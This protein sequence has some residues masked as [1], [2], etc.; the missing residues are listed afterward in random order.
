MHEL[1]ADFTRVSGFQ[2]GDHVAQLHAL[3]V[4]E[5]G[6]PRHA[7]EVGFREAELVE[8][9]PRIALRLLFERVDVG[10]GMAERPV[11]VDQRHHPAEKH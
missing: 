11:V 10:L 7:V 9:E 6:V 2:S 1:E 5:V 3:A 8:V 4:A